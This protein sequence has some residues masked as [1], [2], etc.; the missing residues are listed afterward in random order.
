M[1]GR[2]LGLLRRLRPLGPLP[3]DVTVQ[4]LGGP[5]FVDPGNGEY[6]LQVAS[7]AVDYAGGISGSDFEGHLRDVGAYDRQS[8]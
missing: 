6:H 7:P 3:S 4:Q 2:R 1:R 5:F 8:P